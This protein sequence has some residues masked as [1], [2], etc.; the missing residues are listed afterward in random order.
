MQYTTFNFLARPVYTNAI[1]SVVHFTVK[2]KKKMMIE[3]AA[4][5]CG[6]TIKT[7]FQS[8]Y[9]LNNAIIF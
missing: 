3:S 6:K 9:T 1:R 8:T 4:A 7:Y 5:V 2:L